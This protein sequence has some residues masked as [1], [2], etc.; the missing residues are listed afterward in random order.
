MSE[1]SVTA[2]AAP[3]PEEEASPKR[4]RVFGLTWFSYFFYYFT[5]KPF[6]VAK[7]TIQRVFGIDDTHLSYID[8]TYNAAYPVG[9]FLW[10]FLADKLGYKAILVVGMLASAVLAALFGAAALLV[11]QDHVFTFFLLIWG[12]NGF[13][14]ATGWSPNVKAMTAW[15]PKRGRGSIM[16]IWATCYILGSLAANPFAGACQTYGAG[17]VGKDLAWSFAF[18][19]PAG[20]VAVMA[21]ALLFALPSKRIST[22]TVDAKA[23]AAAAAARRDARGVVMKTP[24]VW[25]L[26]GSYFFLKLTRYGLFA[27]LPFYMNK[28]LG[29]SIG[30]A[31]VAPLAFEFGGAIG[32]TLFGWISE[33]FLAGKRLGISMFCLVCLAG[34]LP[35]YGYAARFG[36]WANM[37]SLFLV[38]FFLY[39][40]DTLLS[41]TAAQDLG[42]PAAAATAA[43]I[44]NGVGSFGQIASSYTLVKMKDM[45]GW[46]I[47]FAVLGVGAVIS[48]LILVPFWLRP[49]PKP[50]SE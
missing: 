35:L 15:F 28:V 14:Q 11:T 18:W 17:I 43:G 50:A 22:V 6:S 45:Y 42:G 19:G 44:I 10:G 16:G 38:G 36:I 9:Q 13:M 48:G 1:A 41:S 29:Y 34:A 21:I 27:W 23:S 49:P 26:G 7:S 30:L 2:G 37:G 12:L 40:P 8:T 24:L 46:S 39:G 25:A 32:S 47:A 20:I 5:R 33:R 4:W 3:V 31:A